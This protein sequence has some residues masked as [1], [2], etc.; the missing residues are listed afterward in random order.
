MK[1]ILLVAALAVV[2]FNALSQTVCE[3]D[4]FDRVVCTETDSDGTQTRS[5]TERDVFGRD[6]TTTQGSDGSTSTS[7]CEYDVFGRYVC[8]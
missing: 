8:N 7:T 2:S 3:K 4:V 5:T 6:V 1:K